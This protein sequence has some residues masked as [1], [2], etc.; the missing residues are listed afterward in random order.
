MHSQR[1]K[2][3]QRRGELCVCDTGTANLW[4]LRR[5]SRNSQWTRRN[6]LGLLRIQEKESQEG[7]V[8]MILNA[9]RK[10][11]KVSITDITG[12]LDVSHL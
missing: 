4:S 8:T 9:T 5:L 12:D 2:S 6:Q 3:R 11:R 7:R 1:S 10:S